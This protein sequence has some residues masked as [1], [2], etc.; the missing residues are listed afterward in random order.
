MNTARRITFNFL[1]LTSG[2][3]ISKI[4]QIFIFIY[5]ARALGKD[6]FGIFSFGISFAFI[7]VIIAN[8]GLSTLLVREI[9]M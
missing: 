7:I 4:L 8:F 3:I 5:L 2:E 6:D 1:S 9:S